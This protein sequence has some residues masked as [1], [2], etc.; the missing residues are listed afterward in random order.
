MIDMNKHIEEQLSAISILDIVNEQVRNLIRDEVIKE[1]KRSI[2]KAVRDEVDSV[3]AREVEIMLSG[4]VHT[5]DG[6]G[7]KQDYDTFEALFKEVFRKKLN[8]SHEMRRTLSRVIEEKVTNAMTKEYTSVT[9]KLIAEL[10][11]SITIKQ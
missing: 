7:N 3:I 10:S 6:W 9:E 2:H 8:E 1:A 4:P 11:K 5:D